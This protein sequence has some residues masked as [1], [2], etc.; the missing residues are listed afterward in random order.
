MGAEGRTSDEGFSF[1]KVSFEL[2][3]FLVFYLTYHFVDVERR[4]GQ[5]ASSHAQVD[6]VSNFE[7]LEE[8]RGLGARAGGLCSTPSESQPW[9][10]LGFGL[11]TSYDH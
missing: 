10:R 6:D 5:T 8:E 4:C 2:E 9:R 7:A 3:E 1:A 11:C